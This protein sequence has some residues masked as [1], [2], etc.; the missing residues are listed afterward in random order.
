MVSGG[1]SRGR[2]RRRCLS[3]VEYAEVGKAVTLRMSRVVLAG[4]FRMGL[5]STGKPA[6][7]GDPFGSDVGQDGGDV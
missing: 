4:E 5:I 1:C 2:F 6:Y 3:G 7:T